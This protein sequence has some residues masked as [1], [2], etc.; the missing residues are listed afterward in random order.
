MQQLNEKIDKNVMRDCESRI[1]LCGALTVRIMGERLEN[2]LPGKQ[3]RL[4]FAFLVSQQGRSVTRSDM[5][6]LL[7]NGA[8]PNDPDTALAALLAKL[9]KSLSKDS[10]SG[11]QD[12]RLILPPA[13]WVDL[14]VVWSCLHRAES[15]VHQHDWAGAWGPSQSVS[16]ISARTF[17]PG[18]EGPWVEEIRSKLMDAQL[19]ANECLA[20]SGLHLGGL[21][22][23]TAERAARRAMAASPYRESTCALLLQILAS[24]G[25]RA[26]AL[27]LYEAMRT[28]LRE[29]LGVAPSETLQEV[30]RRLLQNQT[31][32]G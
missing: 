18:F 25:N 29:E 28:L 22:L 26:E 13:T 19:R 16:H 7:W 30:H 4:L 6:K 20:T 23:Q 9:R 24:R 14:D 15:A 32:A 5:V 2:D 1:H 21:E 31:T 17:M 27:H 3:G 8:P 11:K 10:L 12:V